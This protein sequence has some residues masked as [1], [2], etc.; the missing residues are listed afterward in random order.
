VLRARA[1]PKMGIVGGPAIEIDDLVHACQ[2][3]EK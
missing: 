3:L 1:F 2:F